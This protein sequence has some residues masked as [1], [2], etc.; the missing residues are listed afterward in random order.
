VLQRLLMLVVLFPFVPS[1]IPATDTQP[2]FLVLLAVSLVL[3]A[4]SS[5]IGLAT[6][7]VSLAGAAGVLLV[8]AI[9]Y[10][11][12]IVANSVQPDAT[13]LSRFASFLQFAG[14]VWWAYSSR[15]E[16]TK[17]VILAALLAYAILTVVYFATGGLLED[18]LIRSRT[19]DAAFLFATGRGART[20]APEPSFFALQIFNIFVL[21]RLLR[22][23]ERMS[24]L[25]RSA[26]VALTVGCLASSLSAYGGVIAIVVLG[27]SYPRTF[28]VAALASI[29]AV[30]LL[31]SHFE[32]WQ[33][34]RVIRILL[35]V[36]Q[37]GGSVAALITSDAS[38]SSRV[39]SFSEY[40]RA[41]R[42]HPIIGNALSLN[43]GG[44]FISLIAGFGMAGAIFFLV[45]VA[46]IALGRRSLSTRVLLLVWFV[47][48]FISGP[49]GVPIL[50]VI[51]GRIFADAR[52]A[53]PAEV[54]GTPA[55]DRSSGSPGGSLRLAG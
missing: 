14:A 17:R 2:T 55:G 45:L 50:G 34:V 6:Y 31:Y 40:V 39:G 33:S 4:M 28:A 54:P 32:E 21:A 47:I 43:Q 51:I 49:I 13:S 18:L 12:L 42:E 24:R 36:F 7:R 30:G 5:T 52:S 29:S 20:L 53:D 10:G 46:R 25:E 35:L 23:P 3:A 44:G 27:V 9:L 8:A 11:C 38:F 48:N 26:F 1:I 37:S 41:F 15:L 16:W 19:E 22:L